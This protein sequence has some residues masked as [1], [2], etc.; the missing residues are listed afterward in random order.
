MEFGKPVGGRE[1][2]HKTVEVFRGAE[3]PYGVRVCR[4]R[5]RRA[6]V[7]KGAKAGERSVMSERFSETLDTNRMLCDFVGR[8]GARGFIPLAV[9]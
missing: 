6:D 9:L 2:P 5:R 7:K 1:N 3:M 4:R 8:A